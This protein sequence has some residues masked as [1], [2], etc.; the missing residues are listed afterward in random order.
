MNK[1]LTINMKLK[2]MYLQRDSG[3]L[4]RPMLLE[5]IDRFFLD[6]PYLKPDI[7]AQ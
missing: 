6:Y 4:T 2:K 1:K 3:F 7:N 5:I